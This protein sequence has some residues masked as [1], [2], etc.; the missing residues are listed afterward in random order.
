[1]PTMS[2]MGLRYTFKLNSAQDWRDIGTLTQTSDIL[3]IGSSIEV[4]T[5]VGP[6]TK[7]Y[8]DL[9]YFLGGDKNHTFYILAVDLRGLEPT[10]VFEGSIDGINF[11]CLNK[12]TL[13]EQGKSYVLP[14]QLDC[15][16]GRLRLEDI[17]PS[18]TVQVDITGM[19][20]AG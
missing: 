1:M 7:P 18:D 9:R 19:G 14:I 8:D 11:A 2:G 17:G 5:E 12:I 3:R 10:V 13:T 16:H 4:G 20:R 15:I 6:Q